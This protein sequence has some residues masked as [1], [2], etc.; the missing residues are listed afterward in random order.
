MRTR[1]SRSR[2]PAAFGLCLLLGVSTAAPP[3]A[4]ADWRPS[5]APPLDAYR[6]PLD[7]LRIDLPADMPQGDLDYLALDL[8]RVDVTA[9]VY[10]DGA[11][12]VYEPP[13]ALPIGEHRLRLVQYR[14]DGGVDVRGDW[15]FDVDES[16]ADVTRIRLDGSA[17]LTARYRVADDGSR[18]YGA[19]DHGSGAL[20]AAGTAAN[21]HGS[22]EGS[23]SLLYDSAG[24]PV[25]ADDFDED[26]TARPGTREVEL[27]EYV[28]SAR[29]RALSSTLGHHR[30]PRESLVMRDFHR[31]GA[32]VTLAG[33]ERFSASGFALRAEPVVGFDRIT[34]IDDDDDRVVGAIA[35]G[36]LAST[37]SGDLDL[38][39]MVL[40]GEGSDRTG[41]GIAAAAAP[42]DGDA[43]SV[44]LA[45]G[46]HD[47]RLVLRGEVARSRFDFDSGD[48]D[49]R[50][51]EDDA[52]QFSITLD[53]WRSR[54]I[55]DRP[56]YWQTQLEYEQIGT[57]FRSVANP[58]AIS[59]V[60]ALRL[61]SA[62]SALGWSVDARLSREQDNVDDDPSIAAY[63]SDI[64]SLFASFTPPRELAGDT[65]GRWFGQPVFL[66]GV[67]YTRQRDVST[68]DIGGGLDFA[69]DGVTRQF[70]FGA[71][72]VHD[73][74][75]WGFNHTFGE[76]E[77][78]L[79]RT[80]DS[81]NSLTDLSLNYRFGDRL[82]LGTQFQRSN[83]R[84]IGTGVDIDGYLAGIN[85][86]FVIVPGRLSGSTYL[87]WHRQRATDGSSSTRTRTLDLDLQWQ[88]RAPRTN[89]PGLKVFLKGQYQQVE[90]N[91]FDD[92]ED[93]PYQ[94]FVGLTMDAPF[95]LQRPR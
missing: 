58:G 29:S 46:F 27:G 32:S 80:P 21:A 7:P 12:L 28:L 30:L 44:A 9:R 36:T 43:A 31:R 13:A 50:K 14:P 87:S 88:A 89:R 81:E 77:D 72:F 75:D 38:T 70:T 56:A 66:F 65:G 54:L 47:E 83:L 91:R 61:S 3:T 55:G 48:A 6:A 76:S 85:A 49:D 17:S 51:I 67:D 63:Q 24:V 22:V 71:N 60:R 86:Y 1:S 10:V 2:R 95:S 79:D 57:F 82:Y 41:A 33:R 19:V 37:G 92:I 8:D 74:W 90:D 69:L 20:D 18:D 52:Y 16:A 94:V 11:Q 73:R 78:R 15:R 39:A 26:G 34:G 64:A 23:A 40:S 45:A 25:D 42:V 68:P 93:D 5:L 62:F 53:P 35:S 84:E 59:D 4:H